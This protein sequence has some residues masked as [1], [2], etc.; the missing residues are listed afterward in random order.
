[1]EELQLFKHEDFGE[2]RTLVDEKGEPLFNLNDVC[3]ILEIKQVAG[4]KRRLEDDV[5]SNHPIKDKLNRTQQATFVNEDGLYDVIFD[6]RKKE[7]RAFRKWV[8]AEVL[9]TIRKDGGYISSNITDE[10]ADKLDKKLLLSTPQRRRKA[11]EE[12]TIDGKENVYTVYQDIREYIKNQPAD[13][14]V[15]R[16]RH[17]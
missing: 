2:V 17:V 15:K 14:K 7:A 1:M 11:L 3:K 10:Q 13:E 12:A 4:I 16:L 9:P 6:S 5:I 8:T